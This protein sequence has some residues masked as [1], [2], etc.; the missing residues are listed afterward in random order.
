MV[1][2]DTCHRL[3]S[4]SIS[5]LSRSVLDGCNFRRSRDYDEIV[6]VL[7]STYHFGS[8]VSRTCQ[9]RHRLEFD[10][11]LLVGLKR[12]KTGRNWKPIVRFLVGVKIR[13]WLRTRR[14]VRRVRRRPTART[15]R[16][17]CAARIRARLGGAPRAR[18]S[19]SVSARVDADPV[20][21]SMPPAAIAEPTEFAPNTWEPPALS[22]G[23]GL[24]PFRRRRPS[25]SAR[26]SSSRTR[27]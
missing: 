8:Q 3:Y 22:G 19:A 5:E 7:S 13:R 1:S 14:A 6:V 25:I 24:S 17:R 26:A 18:R 16:P 9:R 15:T 11:Q 12:L 21:H 2:V 4:V 20:S 23:C 27:Q 10:P